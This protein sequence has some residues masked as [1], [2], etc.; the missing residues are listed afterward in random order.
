MYLYICIYNYQLSER[1]AAFGIRRGH[2]MK[3]AH[4]DNVLLRG[5]RGEGRPQLST[6]YI[7][8]PE[9]K[10]PEIFVPTKKNFSP[11]I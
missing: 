10:S 9:K 1:L 3:F 11:D 7:K 6:L 8:S 2:F 5:L 4:H